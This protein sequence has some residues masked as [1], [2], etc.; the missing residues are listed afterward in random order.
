MTTAIALLRAI[1][2]AG[3]NTVRMSELRDLVSGLGMRN[4]RSLLQ[5]GNLVFETSSHV[6]N[7]GLERTFERAA[8]EQLGLDADFMIRSG[9]EW[10]RIVAG[11]PFPR[12]AERKPGHLVVMFL[13]GVPDTPKVAALRAAIRG[14][15][16]IRTKGPHAYIVYPD[17]IGRSRLTTALIEEKLGVRGTGRNWNTVLKLLAMSEA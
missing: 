11:N 7:A 12:E 16:V 1:N 13:K 3:H 8:H 5:S 6:K 9:G 2:V 10:S 15:E 4:V 14:R 17:G